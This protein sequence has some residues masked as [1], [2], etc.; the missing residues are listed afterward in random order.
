MN[1]K[2]AWIRTETFSLKLNENNEYKNGSH[3]HLSIYGDISP[4]DLAEVSKIAKALENI[5]VNLPVEDRQYI[6]TEINEYKVI[7]D[8]QDTELSEEPGH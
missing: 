3:F 1:L 2:S 7:A 8:F 6:E 5:L 4:R